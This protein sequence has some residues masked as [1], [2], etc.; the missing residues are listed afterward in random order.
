VRNELIEQGRASIHHVL[1]DSGWVSFHIRSD[2]D[3]PRAIALLRLNYDRPWTLARTLADPVSEASEESFPA[4][5]A[6]AFVPVTRA[7]P[8]KRE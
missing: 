5:D 2:D 8:K 6:P 4:S 1:P 7:T 3:L